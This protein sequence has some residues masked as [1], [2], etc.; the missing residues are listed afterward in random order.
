[1]RYRTLTPQEDQ[2]INKKATEPP[3]SGEYEETQEPGVYVCKKCDSP[4]FLSSGKFSSHCGWPSFDEAIP[5]AVEQKPD[6]DGR[7][8]EILCKHC[9]A[10]LGHV[11]VGEHL[12]DK[13]TRYCVNSLSML[14]L[15]LYTKEGYERAIFAGGCFWGVE[16]LMKSIPGV[17]SVT[18]GYTGGHV[19]NPTYEEVSR[20]DTGHFEAVEVIFDPKKTTYEAIAK[21]FF[22]IHDPTQSNGQGPDIGSQYRSAIFYLS[23]EQK[24]TAIKLIDIL[25]K[26]GYNVVT[27]VLPAQPFYRAE[28]YHQHYYD[29]SGSTPYCHAPVKRFG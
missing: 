25:K 4:L 12:T 2:I 16:Y 23:P 18:S 5:G 14:F 10:H 24:E 28:E 15:P 22:E 20:G 27:Q 1:M 19:V 7:R 17:I 13:N 21:R 11:F 6:A 29:K 26:R 9:G 3:G 8:V